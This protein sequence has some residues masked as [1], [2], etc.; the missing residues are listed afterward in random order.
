MQF[1][2][3]VRALAAVAVTMTL[4]AGAAHAQGAAPAGIARAFTAPGMFADLRL[5]G[6]FRPDAEVQVEAGGTFEADALGI[7]CAGRINAE[8]PDI[9]LDFTRPAGPLR[10][11]VL[12]DA[13]TALVVRRPNGTWACDD[14][15]YELNPLVTIEKPASGR[16][17]IWVATLENGFPPA[18]VLISESEPRWERGGAPPLAGEAPPVTA[19]QLGLLPIEVPTAGRAREL[20]QRLMSP[21]AEL[22]ALEDMVLGVQR[23]VTA[24][25]DGTRLRI[26]LPGLTMAARGAGR[27]LF[28][29]VTFTVRPLP[30]GAFQ[31]AFDLPRSVEA[32]DNGRT[33]GGLRLGPSRASGTWST[34][35]QTFTALRIELNGA[36]GF[37]VADRRER[38]QL[39]MGEFLLSRDVRAQPDGL[40]SGGY[41]VR[42]RNLALTPT[43]EQTL[44]IGNLSLTGTQAEMDLGALAELNEAFGIGPWLGGMDTLDPG[45]L[46]DYL[47]EAQTLSWGKYAA[48]FNA[49]G[50]VTRQGDTEYTLGRIRLGLGADLT[51]ELAQVDFRAEVADLAARM[52]G[53]LPELSPRAAQAELRLERLPLK[54]FLAA[55]AFETAMAGGDLGETADMIATEVL[56]MYQPV[57]TVRSAMLRTDVLEVTASGRIQLAPD[58]A[59]R[60]TFDATVKGL[61]RTVDAVRTNRTRMANG[62]EML[63]QLTMLQGL[64]QAE[65]IDGAIVHRYHVVWDA[66][67]PLV[68]GVRVD[69][70]RR[71]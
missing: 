3:H 16:Y 55:L 18:R 6:G 11:Y 9:T 5:E 53:A 57:L 63:R 33:L 66:E 59:E 38:T 30:S 39:A 42:L 54:D 51:G 13:D 10:I 21:T 70:L 31:F 46:V 50:V 22:L 68:N 32:V 27:G 2:R 56:N 52:D 19:E 24:E 69:E 37:E 61:G 25:D 28:G 14:D 44:R 23:P 62:D 20:V 1:G 15:T 67:G 43:A 34:P 58:A 8:A 36:N 7:D 47:Y 35:L 49:D 12:S 29:D 64:G 41:E 71:R 48:Q 4:A 45:D 40:W 26:T 65:V 17:L 60:A